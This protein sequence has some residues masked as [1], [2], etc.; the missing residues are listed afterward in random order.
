MDYFAKGVL[1]IGMFLLM[2]SLLPIGLVIAQVGKSIETRIRWG[3]LAC[4]I[5]FAIGGYLVYTLHGIHLNGVF[6]LMI[7]GILFLVASFVWMVAMTSLETVKDVKRMTHLESDKVIESSM[8]IYTR[9]YCDKRIREEITRAQRFNL[10]LSV[11]IVGI[12]NFKLV[13][14]KYSYKVGDNVLM[15]LGACVLD[16][17]RSNDIVGRYEGDMICIIATNTS[18]HEA[19]EL[20]EN[21]CRLVESSTLFTAQ[22]TDASD[23]L[24][25]TVSIGVA[26]IHWEQANSNNIVTEALEA[27]YQAKRRGRNCVAV[28]Y[29][30]IFDAE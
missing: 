15:N 8:G 28:A 27:M 17:S 13:N 6:D 12:D 30:P 9:R 29:K 10:P 25:I 5:L 18:A 22:E 24:R 4:V 21:L 2:G 1:I 23:V 26:T 19:K 7:P 14:E 3:I 16:A 20:A 11:L